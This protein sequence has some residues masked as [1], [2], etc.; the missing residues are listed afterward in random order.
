[1]LVNNP[2]AGILFFITIIFNVTHLK[3]RRIEFSFVTIKSRW[4]RWAGEVAR[5]VEMRNVAKKAA[6]KVHLEGSSIGLKGSNLKDSK[7]N[8]VPMLD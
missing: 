2:V 4:I 5:I 8:V 7:S 6:G 1:L 3:L